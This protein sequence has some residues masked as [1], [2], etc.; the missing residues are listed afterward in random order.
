[1]W[2][3]QV[4]VPR[5]GPWAWPL[6][7]SEHVPQMPS[8]Q[9]WSNVMGSWPCSLSRSFTMSSISRNEASSLMPGAS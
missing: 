6:I 5:S 7:M 3:W 9:S 8:R 4:A 2:S 1:M